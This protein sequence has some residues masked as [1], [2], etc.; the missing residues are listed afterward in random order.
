MTT[1][2]SIAGF[3]LSASTRN[4]DRTVRTSAS[5]V[6]WRDAAWPSAALGVGVVG[7]EH[8]LH[9]S[10]GALASGGTLP[11]LILD[12]ALA[13]PL[14]FVAIC[15]ARRFVPTGGRAR[16]LLAAAAFC[17]LLVPT[18]GV[19][20]S[21]HALFDRGPSLRPGLAHVNPAQASEH[22]ALL[23]HGIRDAL[24]AFPIA[25]AIA[26]VVIG[27]FASRPTP[28]RA[29]RRPRVVLL[30]V[31]T[32]VGVLPVSAG[33][34][35]SITP[36]AV[37]L[38]IPEVLT[39]PDITLTAQA[40]D[41]AILPGAPTSMWTFNGTF[42]GP[43]IRRPSGEPTRVTVENDLPTEAGALTLHHHGNHS[44]SA[45]DGQPMDHLI[46][47][48]DQRTYTYDFLEG[49]TPEQPTPERGAFQWYHDHQMDVTGRDVWMGLAGMVILD[50]P[51]EA[52]I[53]AQLPNGDRDVPLMVADRTFNNDHQIP[54]TFNPQGNLGNAILV[55]GA[56]QPYHEVAD[57]KY[58]FRILNASNF[59]SYDFSLSNGAAMTQVATESGLLPVP[60]TR[61]HLLLGPAERAEV[62]VDFAGELGRTIILKNSIG[63]GPNLSEVMQ[64]CVGTRQ[65]INSVPTCVAGTHQEDVSSI[66]STLR[67][68]QLFDDGP[69]TAT[70]AWVFGRDVQSDPAGRWTINAKG[71][72]PARI[73]AKPKLGTVER[74]IFANATDVDHIVH[75]H[76]VDW[77]I[78]SRSPTD[79]P[80]VDGLLGEE[81]LRESFRLVPNEVV[82]L[83][84]RFTD[85]LGRYVLHCHILEHEDYSM[86]AQ[87][88]VIN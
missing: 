31:A 3:R 71:F 4:E 60:V 45:D 38:P 87:F 70:R 74:W 82:T 88:E 34:S 37:P 9:V 11:H 54:Y 81:G 6:L 53:N 64:F 22:A 50:D 40:A 20:R 77:R 80:N 32:V 14:A 15:I 42:P 1:E 16:S 68:M 13:F 28:V 27:R 72:D 56:P 36:F 49:G 46:P 33:A 24:S 78:V 35:V 69:L 65:L 39:S 29:R 19:H 17:A 59:R 52:E 51:A 83:E 30:A 41:V 25:F 73:D 61:T 44:A 79:P 7:W 10:S 76:D 85:H 43:T 21:I 55:N 67:P 75:I 86:M 23:S 12:S 57:T 18:V 63:F 2:R 47:Q 84:S 8:A 26:L 58:R 5:R 48:G 66:P 62:V